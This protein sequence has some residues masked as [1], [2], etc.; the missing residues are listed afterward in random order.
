MRRE[1]GAAVPREDRAPMGAILWLTLVSVGGLLSATSML[2]LFLV[3][4]E[5]AMR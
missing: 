1:L 4:L 5:G 2:I 3:M